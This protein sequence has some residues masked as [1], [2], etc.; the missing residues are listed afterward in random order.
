VNQNETDVQHW[1][2][3]NN[4]QGRGTRRKKIRKAIK[5]Q[6][7]ARLS[8][9]EKNGGLGIRPSS[10][11]GHQTLC[12]NCN[13]SGLVEVLEAPM[14]DANNY[15]SLAIIGGGIG[16][17][18]LAVAC[19]HRNIPFTLFER[20][21]DF[22]A[23]KQGYG[24]TL[25]QASK[26]IKA[27]GILEL[28]G[29]IVSTRHA[30]HNIDGELIGEWGMRKWIQSAEEKNP[31]RTNVHI[32]R[33]ELRKALFHQLNDHNQVKW[34]HQ[35]VDFNETNLGVE[36]KFLV[37]GAVVKRSADIIVGADGIRSRVR[38]QLVNET[39]TPLRYL[40]C[41][42]ILGI[43]PLDRLKNVQSELLDSET[44]FQ[45]VNGYERMYM[46]P[47]RSDAIMWQFSF[48]INEDEAKAMSEKGPEHLKEEAIKRTKW[49]S[50]IPE[51]LNA[52]EA[53]EVTGYPVYDRSSL[54]KHMLN[55]AGNAT[56]IGDAAHPMSPFKGQGANQ[57]L[58]DALSLA[59]EITKSCGPFN[60]W[61]K[62]NIRDKV[63]SNFE[64]E[65][66]ERTRVKVEDSA[67]AV[68]ILHSKKVLHKS[69]RPRGKVD[70]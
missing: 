11:K 67:E 6:Y 59:R 46:M 33:Q 70:L 2:S 45:T 3:C 28:D 30:V 57:A 49:H 26:S 56:L 23:R 9:F 41:I 39:L 44:V 40:G 21:T 24:L 37:N 52:T 32:P 18:A 54:E 5:A 48:P 31:R 15:P 4:C 50:P 27:F 43:C 7:L 12:E 62:D 61:G 34:G 68:N 64:T 29:G 25:Q 47:Y 10:P 55:S 8:Q 14:A 36:L 20:D 60:S 69:N 35:L 16:G 66:I 63:L 51:I 53:N 13:G 17:T 58:L 19:L 42:V 1:R 38:Q 22:D 65:M